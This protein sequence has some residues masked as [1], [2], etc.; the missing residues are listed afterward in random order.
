[1]GVHQD[2]GPALPAAWQFVDRAKEIEILA[3]RAAEFARPGPH[4]NLALAQR[5]FTAI[6]QL[7]SKGEPDG[8]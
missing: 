8:R 4:Q 3:R 2:I 7:T 6:N 5:Q 1:M